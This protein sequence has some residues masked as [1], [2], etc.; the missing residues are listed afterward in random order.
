MEYAQ[1]PWNWKVTRGPYFENHLLGEFLQWDMGDEFQT[2]ALQGVMADLLGGDT[3]HHA[4]NIGISGE[5]TQARQGSSDKTAQ[6]VMTS[7]LQL[8]CLI[9]DEIRGVSARSLA[10]I[11]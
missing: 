10:E 11:D 1:W 4:F 5:K 3:I 7:L 6:D 8:R 9:V 2:V